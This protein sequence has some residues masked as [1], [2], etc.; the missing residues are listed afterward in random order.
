MPN[1]IYS[2]KLKYGTEL[3]PVLETLLENIGGLESRISYG[4]K[5]LIKPNLVAPI[6]KATTDLML[7][8]FFITKIRDL[9]GIPIIGESSGFEFDTDATFSILGINQ[10]AEERGVKLINFEREGYTKI[11]LNNGL[12]S[13]EI[14]SVVD[15]VKLIINLAVLKKHTITKVTGSVKNLFGLLSKPSRRYLHCHG[16][17][18]GIAA[19]A[20][21]L[22]NVIHFLDARHLLSRAVFGESIPLNYCLAGLDPFGLDHFGSRLLGIDPNEVKHLKKTKAY[23]I[24]G[25]IPDAFPPCSKT[26]SLKNRF[27]RMLYSILYWADDIKCSILGGNSIIPLLHWY[28]GIHP[29]L[30][31]VTESELKHLSMFC[32]VGAIN[33][34]KRKIIKEKCLK[35]RCLKCYREL[36]R[37][38]VKLKGFNRPKDSE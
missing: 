12:R 9:G 37:G 17:D 29:E 38:K 36:G 30:G 8:D 16:L 35:V 10:F 4:D 32:P 22:E 20:I 18:E 21:R 25:D 2:K 31:D 34:E 6:P 5:V 27:H 23:T 1:I 19:L 33:I 14:T 7:I 11:Y 13:I 24:E 3:L 26:S 28:L 15:D